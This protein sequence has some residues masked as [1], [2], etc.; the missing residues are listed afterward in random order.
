MFIITLSELIALSILG[1]ILVLWLVF[2][3]IRGIEIFYKWLRSGA[4]FHEYE[5]HSTNSAGQLHWYRCKK[6]GKKKLM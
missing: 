1:I 6:C 4:C 3:T 2:W 5:L